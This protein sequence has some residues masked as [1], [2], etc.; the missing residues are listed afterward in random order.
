MA[1]DLGVGDVESPYLDVTPGDATT[2]GTLTVTD[3]A[4]EDTTPAVTPGAPSGGTVR[5]TAAAITYDQPGRWV[6][7]WDVTGTGEGAEDVEMYVVA[8]PV[9]GG[10]TW[11]PG[12]SRVA[13]YVPLRTLSI[14]SDTH[15]Q[16]FSS[17]TRPNG[18]QTDRLIAD[19]VL[20]VTAATGTVDDTLG[21]VAGVCASLRAAAAVERGFPEQDQVDAALRR[22]D[23]LDA[24]AE[25]MRADLVR[26][27]EAVTGGNSTDP[28]S[29]LLPVYSFP[30]PVVHGDWLL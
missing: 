9:A 6:L 26:A 4:G 3:P 14:A 21:D 30:T 17:T 8:S 13:N 24:R 2:D 16:T 20:W 22:A 5:L 1:T 11:T 15:E 23:A 10:P 19:A 27:N 28:T 18:I 7:H 29:G 25:A 12:R